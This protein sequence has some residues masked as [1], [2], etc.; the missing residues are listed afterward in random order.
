MKKQENLIEL[1]ELPNLR[2]G[3][4]LERPN[5]FFS[6]IKYNN[7]IYSAH[8]HDPGRLQELLV[9]G[10]FVL[11]SKSKGKLDYYLKAVKINDEWVL[12]DTALHSKIALKLI[13]LLPEFSEYKKIEKEKSIG[14]SRIDFV[15]NGIPLEVKGVTLVKDGFALF[16]DAPTKRG[17]RHV[18][19]II[20]YNGMLL[21][22][23]FRNANEFKPNIE[24]DPEFSKKLSEARQKKIPIYTA[25]IKFD[26]EKV[27]YA[28]KI[29]LADF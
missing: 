21:F 13:K 19:E 8:I 2:K 10:R 12:I 22:L 1:F 7:K 23:I 5:R 11:F 20:K 27:Y 16:P 29:P 25:R 14:H 4:F 3:V 6:F 17:F 28:G 26:G 15:L 18:N 24:T 9:K